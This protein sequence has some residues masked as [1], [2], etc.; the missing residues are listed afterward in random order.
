[1]EVG[2]CLIWQAPLSLLQA[3][4]VVNMPAVCEED[5]PAH[6]AVASESSA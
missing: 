2:C 3:A 1:M 6:E 5:M 4:A